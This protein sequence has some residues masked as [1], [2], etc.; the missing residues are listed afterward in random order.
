MTH[1]K[2]EVTTLED[3][4]GRM[5]DEFNK[6]SEVIAAAFQPLF[7]LMIAEANSSKLTES[8]QSLQAISKKQRGGKW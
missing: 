2:P 7:E 8:Q 1:E 6:L 3:A 4:L 5:S